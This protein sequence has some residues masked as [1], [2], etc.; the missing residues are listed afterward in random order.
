MQYT[1]SVRGR[2]L[3][4]TA[5]FLQRCWISYSIF[6]VWFVTQTVNTVLRLRLYFHSDTGPISFLHSLSS[7]IRNNYR[8]WSGLNLSLSLW[9]RGTSEPL[10][11]RSQSVTVILLFWTIARVMKLFNRTHFSDHISVSTLEMRLKIDENIVA[12]RVPVSRNFVWN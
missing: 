12:S 5:V 2:H 8:L 11:P 10:W 6:T 1:G 4:P 9:S 7:P 3:L